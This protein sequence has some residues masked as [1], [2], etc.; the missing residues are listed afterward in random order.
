M[1]YVAFLNNLS[2]RCVCD[3]GGHDSRW[4]KEG[5]RGKG[6]QTEKKKRREADQGTGAAATQAGTGVG[7]ASVAGDGEVEE[8][9]DEEIDAGIAAGS[10]SSG[11]RSARA[12]QGPLLK[13]TVIGKGRSMGYGWPVHGGNVPHQSHL[14]RNDFATSLEFH[15]VF[16]EVSNDIANTYNS[17]LNLL[18]AT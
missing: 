4:N 7:V 6:S 12:R 11:K 14:G 13:E 5:G 16:S 1:F 3:N 2:W 8:W 15:E 17:S 9:E 18:V 10:A